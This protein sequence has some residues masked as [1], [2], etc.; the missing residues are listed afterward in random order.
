MIVSPFAQYRP[1]E[2]LTLAVNAFNVFDRLAIVQLGAAAIPP[3]G[4]ANVQVM[5]GRTVTASLRY[6]F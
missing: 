1:T 4:I 6:A 5:N 2:R 3:S